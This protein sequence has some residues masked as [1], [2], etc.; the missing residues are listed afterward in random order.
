MAWLIVIPPSVRANIA[1][2]KAA[3]AAQVEA[4]AKRVAPRR[5]SR[6]DANKAHIRKVLAR[7]RRDGSFTAG[8]DLITSGGH[9]VMR[10]PQ[11]LPTSHRHAQ[12]AG[13]LSKAVCA[14]AST[15]CGLVRVGTQLLTKHCGEFGRPGT[16]SRGTRRTSIALAWSSGPLMR[17]GG[18]VPPSLRP[19]PFSFAGVGA[20]RQ[21]DRLNTATAAPASPEIAA[22]RAQVERLR[23]LIDRGI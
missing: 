12:S 22:A 19:L 3:K 9:Q 6:A 21:F 8:D 11:L 17:K 13:R 18:G 20:L 5:R 4:A 23:H 2:K 10:S 1:A 15:P 16:Y 14:K 7:M